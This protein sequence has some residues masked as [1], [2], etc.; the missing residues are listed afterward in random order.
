MQHFKLARIHRYELY[1]N[2]NRYE[3]QFVNGKPE[4]TGTYVWSNS[5]IY[6]G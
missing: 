4:G 2:Q 1:P 6:D 3:G 5:E